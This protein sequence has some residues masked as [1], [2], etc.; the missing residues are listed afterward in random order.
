M[1]I[2]AYRAVKQYS[3]VSSAPS[4]CVQFAIPR[5]YLFGSNAVKY[6]FITMSGNAILKFIN[7]SV[8][9]N[10]TSN[11]IRNELFVKGFDGIAFFIKGLIC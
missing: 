10:L 8:D 2:R 1:A 5:S 6:I 7:C 9:I 11:C 4:I 3:F